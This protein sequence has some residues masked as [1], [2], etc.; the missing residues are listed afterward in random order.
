MRGR[1]WWGA[2]AALIVSTAIVGSTIPESSFADLFLVVSV[3]W[4]VAT[5]GLLARRVWL[6]ATYRV[7]V[8]LFITYLLVGVLPIL[9]AA[10]FAAVGLYILMGQYTSVRLGSEIRRVRWELAHQCETILQRADLQG[11]ESAMALLQEFADA[12]HEPLPHIVWQARFGD[13]LVRLGGVR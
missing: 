3:I 6:W 1:W 12:S 2:G 4:G 13:R 5:L 10:A 7:G 8:R 11:A 9:F